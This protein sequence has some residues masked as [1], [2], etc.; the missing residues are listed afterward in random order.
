MELTL[1]DDTQELFGD[2]VEYDIVFSNKMN[3]G[4][5]PFLTLY[6]RC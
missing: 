4:F 5:W 1:N 6:K 3:H 2:Q